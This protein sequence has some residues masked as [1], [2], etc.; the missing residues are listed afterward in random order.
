[1]GFFK[2]GNFSENSFL[3]SSRSENFHSV[4]LVSSINY[5]ILAIKEKFMALTLDK[6]KQLK[7]A[8]DVDVAM[9]DSMEGIAKKNLQ[10]PTLIQKWT[11][12]YTSQKYTIATQEIDLEELYGNL[13]ADIKVNG[14]YD[15]G[16]KVDTQVKSDKK[17]IAAARE[18]AAQKYY[19]DFICETLANLK[20]MHYTIKNYLEYKKI[21]TTNF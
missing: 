14:N 2:N 19:Y 3:R 5:Y 6:F 13:Y 7:A 11:R 12:Y 16:N 21:Q 20:Q 9:T 10:L 8:A 17:Y 4:L 1:M 18:L 15:W